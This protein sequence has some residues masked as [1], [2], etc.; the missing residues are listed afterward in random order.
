MFIPKTEKIKKLAEKYPNRIKELELVF[1]RNSNVYIDYANVR[2]WAKKLGWR[3]DLKRL[4]QLLNSFDT[5]KEVKFY[6]GTLVGDSM[7]ES[8][9]KNTREYG[10]D[11]KTKPVKRMK[12]S[13]DVSSI[14]PD[15][16]DLLKDFI[17]KPLLQ[18]LKVET[19]E[20][21]NR[22]L[23]S[24]NE[25]GV[26]YIED[27]KSNFDVEIGRDMLRDYDNDNLDNFILWSGDSDFEDP[28]RQLLK[29]HKKVILFSTARR[30][31]SELG[32]LRNDGLVIFDIQKIRDFICYSREMSIAA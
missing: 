21:L 24:L 28:I 18:K 5:V 10:Y 1:D 3:V 22:E 12:L 29:D 20:S 26:F 32:N 7:S 31:S 19:I 17:R 8:M 2:P 30:V 15:S 27:L 11:V 14:S 9:I 16:T 25:Q 23:K 4:K 13:V 6:H